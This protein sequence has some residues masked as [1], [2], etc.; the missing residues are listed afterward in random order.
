MKELYIER[1][2]KDNI[3]NSPRNFPVTAITGPRQCGKST[4]VKHLLG[5]YPDSIYLDLERPSDLRKLENVEWFLTSQRPYLAYIT[6]KVYRVIH[7]LVLFGSQ[8]YY[9]I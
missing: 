8:S 4:L 3:L 5:A 2:C 7:H 9:Q 6:L 1:H